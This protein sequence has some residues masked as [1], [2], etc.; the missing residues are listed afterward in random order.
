M[1][2]FRQRLPGPSPGDVIKHS[3]PQVRAIGS[4][5]YWTRKEINAAVKSS[6][7]IALLF[8]LSVGNKTLYIPICHRKQA[9]LQH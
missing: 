6:S 9:F 3:V 5:N 2:P 7:R 1:S 8:R 4:F